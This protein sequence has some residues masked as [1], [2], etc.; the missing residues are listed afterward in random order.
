[1]AET[2]H[3]LLDLAQF[4]ADGEPAL[5]EYLQ[6]RMHLAQCSICRGYL[7]KLRRVEAALK[8]YPRATADASLRLNIARIVEGNQNKPS[9]WHLLPWTVWV[10]TA[11]IMAASLV[12]LY[13][14]PNGTMAPGNAINWQ[15]PVVFSPDTLGLWLQSFRLTLSQSDLATIGGAIAAILGGTGILWAISSLDPEQ[16]K[17]LDR[18]GNEA[19]D[20]ARR[21]LRVRRS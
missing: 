3:V 11:T 1:M 5:P 8:T 2:T 7:Q 10:P 12:A 14:L 17:Q 21:F 19:T 6:L 18:L 13:L 4:V 16:N 15:A 20:R 9:A